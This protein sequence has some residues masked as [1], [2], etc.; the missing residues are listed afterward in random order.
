[1]TKPPDAELI[2]VVQGWDQAM[3]R[4]DAAAIG[5]YMADDW[6]IIGSDG[7]GSDKATFLAQIESGVLTHNV[8]QTDD[9]VVRIYGEAAVITARGVS[10]GSFQGQPFRETERQ[11]NLF[12]RE[13]GRWR[14]VH[15]HLS[16]LP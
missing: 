14:C 10:G 5:A 12:V 9:I 13:S 11:S 6:T 2:A 3:V 1:M 15:T 7:S 4:N 16:R 8:M